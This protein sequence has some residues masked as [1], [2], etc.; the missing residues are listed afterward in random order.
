MHIIDAAF[1]ETENYNGHKGR[2]DF[3]LYDIGLDRT[4][5]DAYIG[6]FRLSMKYRYDYEFISSG[7][8][9]ADAI[10][11]Q[12]YIDFIESEFSSIIN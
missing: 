12:A 11:A 9:K 8:N 4:V 1:G 3:I 5:Q 10:N 2:N 7:E 6:L